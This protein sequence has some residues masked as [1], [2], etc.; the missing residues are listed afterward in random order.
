MATPDSPSGPKPIP[1]PPKADS[2]PKLTAAGA[3]AAS[4]P[5]QVPPPAPRPQGAELLAEL[6]QAQR[7]FTQAMQEVR[8]LRGKLSRRSHQMQVLQHVSEILAATSKG[9]Q[10]VSVVLEVL[11]Q[12]FRCPRAVVWTLEDGGSGYVPKEGTGLT[13][14]EW[15]AMRLPAPNPFPETPLVLFQSQWLDSPT[16]GAA[17]AALRGTGGGSLYF[18]P[19]EHQLLLMGFVIL[20]MPA[21]RQVE[22]EELDSISILQRQTAI[23]LYNAW[24]F[25]DLS[26]QRD[27]LQRQTLELERVNDALREADQLKS[28]FLALTSHELR[29]PLT[30]ILGF[31]RLVMDGLYDDAEEMRSMLQDSYTSGQHLLGLLNDILD[32]AKIESGRLE[33][34][35]EPTGLSQ[36]L[37]EV[38]PIA[39]AYPRRPGVELVWSDAAGIP[40]VM[41]DSSRLKQVLLNL[42]SNALKFTKEGSVSVVVERHPGIIAL[43]VVDTGIGVSLEGQ[44]RLFQKFA[45]AEG[46]HAREYGGTGL[47]LVICKHLMSMM[48]GTIS[49]HSEGLG[50]GSTLK[51]TMPIA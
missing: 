33:V 18:V 32:L 5:K 11:A 8:D 4:G 20:A 28:E 47:G 39:E 16:G 51:I 43:M 9:G 24:L 10:V 46:G 14:A 42:L 3:K 13:R 34:H 17:L 30:G 15:S 37:E 45:Q 29:T 7:Q 35:C 49:L 2:G 44:A 19:F 6:M 1:P 41:V 38:K 12:E 36:L 25:Q 22:E 23:S 40:E 50:H 31:T 26:E 21:D 48:G 27:A